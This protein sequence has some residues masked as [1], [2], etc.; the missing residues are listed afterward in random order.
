M[1]YVSSDFINSVH[2]INE[3]RP[4]FGDK[5]LEKIIESLSELKLLHKI[6][7]LTIRRHPS[8]SNDKYNTFLCPGLIIQ[9]NCE[10]D[11]V[12]SIANHEYVVG[13]NSMALVIGKL[14]GKNT[15]N[16]L[17]DGHGDE[18]IPSR[19]IDRTVRLSIPEMYQSQSKPEISQDYGNY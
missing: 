3:Q 8:E 9:N 18:T 1:L 7:T 16:F 12:E 14:C 17:I 15:L 2:L 5:I 11:L 4:F 6:T 13:V 19:Y 10:N